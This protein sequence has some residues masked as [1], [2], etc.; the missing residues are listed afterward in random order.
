[1]TVTEVRKD[2]EALRLEFEAEF[3]ATPKRVW[4][5]FADPR[6][7]ERWWGPP[8][9]PATVTEHDLRVGGRIAYHMTS[10]EGETYPGYWVVREVD[11]PQGLVFQDG[12]L[13]EDGTPDDEMPTT[14]TSIRI[15]DIGSGMTRLTLTSDVPDQAALDALLEMGAVE[16]ITSAMGQIDAILAEDATA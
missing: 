11:P 14:V 1:M 10:P 3:E 5:L 2:L 9:Y 7:L 8:Q 15:D 13:G 4:Q 6:Q 16:G 12:F